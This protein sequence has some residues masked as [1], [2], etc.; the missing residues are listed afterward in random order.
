MRLFAKAVVAILMPS[1]TLSLFISF[2]LLVGFLFVPLL[3][4]LGG[5]GFVVAVMVDRRRRLVR[6]VCLFI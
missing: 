6:A 1:P 3:L 4:L 2:W 5:G